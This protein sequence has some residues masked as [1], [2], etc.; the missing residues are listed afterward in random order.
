M[1]L[2]DPACLDFKTLPSLPYD[3]RSRL[4][5]RPAVYFVLTD[6]ASPLIYI[7]ATKSLWVRFLAHDKHSL[8][9]SASH[10]AIA[11]LLFDEVKT[12]FVYEK[13]CLRYWHPRLN[14]KI[15]LMMPYTIFQIRLEK[16][17]LRKARFYLDEEGK[18]V[19]QFLVEQLERYVESH[20]Q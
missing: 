17:L 16:I 10:V 20:E 4:P 5:S 8:F 19:G 1:N 14:R 7:G 13:Q 11:W 18:N 6:E 15:P 9:C 12:C 3:S 2:I